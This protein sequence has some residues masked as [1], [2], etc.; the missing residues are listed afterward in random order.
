MHGDHGTCS[1]L[2]FKTDL[3]ALFAR[4]GLKG[5]K[6]VFLLSDADIKHDRMLVAINDLLS[7]GTIPDLYSAEEQDAVVSQVA[8]KFKGVRNLLVVYSNFKIVV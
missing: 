3:Q 2:D 7:S 8:A 5:D 6:V 1:L 4:A